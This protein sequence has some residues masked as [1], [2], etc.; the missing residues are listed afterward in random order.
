MFKYFFLIQY[1]YIMFNTIP[2]G[3]KK[4]FFEKSKIKD[5]VTKTKSD[6]CKN[7]EIELKTNNIKQDEAYNAYLFHINKLFFV[8]DVDSE[9]ALNY[10]N[11]LIK[12][13]KIKNIQSTKSISNFK[14]VNDFKFHLYFKN[15]LNIESNKSI[16]KLE[17]FVNKLI[18]EDSKRFNKNINIDDLPE[19]NENFYNDLLLFKCPSKN[20]NKIEEPEGPEGQQEEVKNKKNKKVDVLI[21]LEA[22]NLDENDNKIL[23]LVNILNVWRADD[24]NNWFN[25]GRCLFNTNFEYINIFN[26]FSK[27]SN[28]YDSSKIIKTWA[29]YKKYNKKADKALTLGTLRFYANEDNQEDYIKWCSKYK[30]NTK[31]QYEAVKKNFEINNFFIKNPVMYGTINFEGELK[32]RNETEFKTLHQRLKYIGINPITGEDEEKSFIMSWLYDET[33]RQYEKLE[34]LPKQETPDIFYN[35][36]NGFEVE[37]Q[38]EEDIKL[39]FEDSNLF[40]LLNHLCGNDPKV[41]NYVL[42]WIANRVQKPYEITKVA[43]LFKSLQGAGKNLFW[44]WVG[45]SILG[46]KYFFDTEKIDLVFGRFNGLIENII[47]GVINETS[48]KDT[49]NIIELIKG[50]I[51][52]DDNMI[53]HKGMKPYKNKNHIGLVFLTNN[54]NSINIPSDDRRFVGIK[55]NSDICNDPIF[56]PKVVQEIKSKKYDR[57]FYDYLMNINIDGF[58]FTNERP[59]TSFYNDMVELNRPILT[60]FML[61]LYHTPTEEATGTTLFNMFGI[62]LQQMNIVNKLSGTKFGINLKDYEGITKIKSH[63]VMKYHINKPVLKEYLIKKCSI[64]PDEFECDSTG[65]INDVSIKTNN[66]N[67]NKSD[68]D[69]DFID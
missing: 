31:S 63:G 66:N 4:I 27:K 12:K 29:D 46:Q 68:F 56:F 58:D 45:K 6:F 59:K 28:K 49:F 62:Y 34:F 3:T 69:L 35:S 32:L 37:K 1:I 52:A 41:L 14:D 39:N 25:V 64:D 11:T 15:N 50:L 18:F 38:H 13:H 65:F 17:L 9:P 67:N 57:C 51:T 47:L 24:Y 54:S 61:Y 19:L 16:G 8:V 26:E 43:L 42:K 10:V 60:N 21:N 36:F 48:G 20:K 30:Y 2:T 22:N 53:E 40:I 5:E 44:D 55:C 7:Y 23:E 33:A